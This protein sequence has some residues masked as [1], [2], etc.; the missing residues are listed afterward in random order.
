MASCTT[1]EPQQIRAELE[2]I[3]ASPPFAGAHRSRQFLSYVVQNSLEDRDAALKEYTI[4]IEVFGRDASYDPS[5]DATVRVEA[6]RL[7]SRLRD[8]YT[9]DGQSDALIIE[10]PKGGYRA[11]FSERPG[12]AEASQSA[13][14]GAGH[15]ADVVDA[16]L[17]ETNKESRRLRAFAWGFAAVCIMAALAGWMAIRHNHRVATARSQTNA[18]IRLAVLPFANET[19]D[20]AKNYLTDGLTDNLIRQLSELPRLH[21]MTRSAVSR[22]KP[23]DIANA[24]GVTTVLRGRLRRNT[25][26]RLVLSTEVSSAK[27]GTILSSRQHLADESDLASVQA[28]VAQDV[29]QALGI[30]LD[31]DQSAGVRRPATTNAAAFQAFLRGESAARDPSAEGMHAAIGNYEEAIRQDPRFALAYSQLAEAH[32]MLGIYYEP[33]REHLPL[34]RQYAERALRLDP[35]LGEAHGTLG[36]VDLVYDWDLRDADNELTTAESRF[37]A[38]HTLSCTSHLHHV[39]GS[40][41]IRHAEEDMRR[42]LE[43][44]PHSST[45]IGELGCISYYGRRYADSIRYYRE[46]IATDSH[47]PFLYWGEG[48]SLEMQGRYREALEILRQFKAENGF[49]PPIITAEIGYAEG[50]SGDRSSALETVKSLQDL[51]KSAYVDPFFIAIVYHGMKD[52]DH[53][54]QW[55]NR[56]YEARSPFMISLGSDP[57][58]S[59]SQSDP[60]FQQ[61]WNRM[62][63]SGH[64]AAVS[65][66]GVLSVTN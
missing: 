37:S 65:P 56:G 13:V 32:A 21:V 46:A 27:D 49:E 59:D 53:T 66:A 3:L 12:P 50:A 61:I 45:F 15:A 24:L 58:W 31:A 28:D 7:R 55:L 6:S 51:S 63:E 47:A 33:A 30:E 19:G 64:I 34:A 44:D 43:F 29:I 26:G 18:T 2:R 5:I 22:V 38:I 9:G 11:V 57:K 35:H 60:R 48:R 23:A 41:N 52:A 8:Y 14:S 40:D 20:P 4:A 25:D 10:I 17:S 54:Y 39:M 36:L 16:P 62:M 1:L 42:L